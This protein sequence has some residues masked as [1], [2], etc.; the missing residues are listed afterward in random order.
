M[1][2][3]VQTEQY[4]A[5]FVSTLP[6]KLTFCK[7]HPTRRQA[8]RNSTLHEQ[9]SCTRQG[10]QLT[11]VPKSSRGNLCMSKSLRRFRQNYV[12][13]VAGLSNTL[14]YNWDCAYANEFPVAV[15]DVN[16]MP[17]TTNYTGWNRRNV[18][19]FGRVFLML[20]YT[21]KTQNTYIQS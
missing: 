15:E 10:A 3:C 21:E 5:Y 19:N 6:T 7:L 14:S 2:Y 1:I 17:C 20:N 18:P 9:R 13:H 4:S 8:K 11:N 12:L 16:G